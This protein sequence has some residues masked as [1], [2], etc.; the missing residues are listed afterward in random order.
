MK[1]GF[2]VERYDEGVGMA[3]IAFN[4]AKELSENH[5]TVILTP[6]Y[7]LSES[8]KNLTEEQGIKVETFEFGT[9]LKAR[10]RSK[11]Y[12]DKID[13]MN[14]DVL[15][16]HGFVMSLACALSKT[17][18]VS[19]YHAHTLIWKEYKNHPLRIPLWVLEQAP[20]IYMSESMISIS[21]Y[22]KKQLQRLYRKDS[23]VI[24][25]G[26][27]LETYSP[28]TEQ[29]FL[30]EHNI[31]TNK[32]IIGTLCM[33]REYKNIDLAL[34]ALQDT[35]DEYLYLIGG[36]GPR[37]ELLKKK[38]EKYNVNAKFLGFIEEEDLPSYYASLDLFLFPSLWEG[39]GVPILESM[40]CGTPAI[41]LNQKG[42]KEIIENNKNGF[43]LSEDAKEWR[44]TIDEFFES[45]D[46]MRQEARIRAEGFSWE[47]SAR[48]YL[49]E[50]K[51]VAK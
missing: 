4:L 12:A 3:N 9:G 2:A 34:E 39:F 47:N 45:A 37:K 24:Y 14:L 5:E 21:D 49:R 23:E 1:I 15:S 40:A 51:K 18:A 38:A 27:D 35:K 25:N 32:K 48:E 28:D 20:S 41:A 10:L 30:K 26:I 46:D 50:F 16:S 33:L 11:K 22:A 6:D 8:F 42:P 29:E 44:N 43:L 13:S 19:T 17:P 36:N 7:Y 31:D